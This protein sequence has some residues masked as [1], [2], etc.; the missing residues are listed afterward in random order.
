MTEHLLLKKK[1][2]KEK[3]KKWD[4]PKIVSIVPFPKIKNKNLSSVFVI[5]SV[6]INKVLFKSIITRVFFVV[7]FPFLP[8]R[9]K[10]AD[11]RRTWKR[12]V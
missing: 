6:L 12:C 2:E 5:R 7:V 9:T 10:S 1:K 3:N 8:V 11:R 4:T